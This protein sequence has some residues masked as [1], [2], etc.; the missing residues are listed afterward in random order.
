MST[1][2]LK[3]NQSGMFHRAILICLAVFLLAAFTSASAATTSTFYVDPEAFS[4][5]DGSQAAPWNSLH[6]A[7]SSISSSASGN[8]ILNIGTGTCNVNCE[9]DSVL[10]VNNPHGSIS[11]LQILGQGP[12]TTIIDGG[13]ASAWLNGLEIS[14]DNV[15]VEAIGIS[16]FTSG[17]GIYF[18]GVSSGTVKNCSFSSNLIGIEFDGCSN[19]SVID[20]CAITFN[21]QTGVL[22]NES[23]YCEIAGNSTSGIQNNGS[24]QAGYGVK[25]QGTS[26][27]GHLIHNN[28]FETNGDGAQEWQIY[29]QGSTIQDQIYENTIQGSSNVSNCKGIYIENASPAI[30]KNRIVNNYYGI[31][32]TISAAGLE[33][34]PTITNNL[35][36]GVYSTEMLSGISFACESVGYFNT[37]IFHNT[38]STGNGNAIEFY[39]QAGTAN[40]LYNILDNFYNGYGVK[41]A[42]GSGT[43]NVDYNIYNT[44]S[45]AFYG[46]T[47]G[48]NNSNEYPL[49][50]NQASYDYSLMLNS[51]C[52]DFIPSAAGDPVNEDIEGITRPQDAGWDAGAYEYVA[53]SPALYYVNPNV[54]TSGDGSEA[55]PWNSLYEAINWLTTSIT[56][57]VELHAA[58]G[59]YTVSSQGGYETD[60][61]HIISNATFDALTI[62][63]EDP[64][65]TI[66]SGV[67]ASSWTT[68]LMVHT[69]NVVI[70]N[71]TIENFSGCGIKF[72]AT[73]YGGARGCVL[74]NNAYGVE[75][76]SGQDFEIA[77]NEIYHNSLYGIF[78]HD[79]GMVDVYQNPAIYDNGSPVA[80][81]TGIYIGATNYGP[82]TIAENTI[83]FTGDSS[84]HQT[85][86]ISDSNES[87]NDIIS[88]NVITST[89]E[90]A[91][92]TG[93]VITDSN[94]ELN[95][96][97]IFDCAVGIS[98]IQSSTL[99]LSPL[100]LN[101]VIAKKT[102][103]TYG[104]TH[105]ITLSGNGG[106]S[107][108]PSIY[109]NTLYG[110]SGDGIFAT[111]LFSDI[112]NFN[113]N[114]IQDFVGYGINVYL[115]SSCGATA[116]YN[117]IANN[118]MGQYS[119][120]PTWGGNNI[121]DTQTFFNATAG[122]FRLA[123]GSSGVDAIPSGA[124]DSVAY[125]ARY[126][127]RPQNVNWD[128]GA[129]E[130][131]QTSPTNPILDD[132]NPA[133]GI[134]IV[135]TSVNLTWTN[136][137][138]NESGI[139]G[140]YW[141]VDSATNTDPTASTPHF[142]QIPPDTITLN[143]GANYLHIVALDVDG[144]LS[145]SVL[146]AGPWNYDDIP[147]S[148]PT[149]TESGEPIGV[150]TVN[151]S[152]SLSWDQGTDDCGIYG[153]FYYVDSN[154]SGSVTTS[155]TYSSSPPSSIMLNAETNYLHIRS[156]DNSHMLA[157]DTLTIGPWLVDTALPVNPVINTVSVITAT[158]ITNDYVEFNWTNSGSDDCGTVQ[159]KWCIDANPN[160]NPDSV[161]TAVVQSSL[162]TIFTLGDGTN[163]IH[164]VAQDDFNSAT[165]VLH[166]GPWYKDVAKPSNP[167]LYY[168]TIPLDT[169]TTITSTALTWTPGSDDCGLE[170][171]YILIDSIADSDPATL[172]V[173]E[174][175]PET[176]ALGPCTSGLGKRT[177][178][179]RSIRKYL[180]P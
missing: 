122:D 87:F 116:D 120:V 147:P 71:L 80:P 141:I 166:F 62:I 39:E 18:T 38:I 30:Y 3:A 117:A 61:S 99:S 104:L 15:T 170:G 125:D 152:T 145:D 89:V 83:F 158:C 176:L 171:Y 130:L 78:L 82:Y 26:G 153:Y 41:L 42:S 20:D 51:P 8:V 6:E 29:I 106:A 110:G 95:G 35:I 91:G 164:L 12:Y 132:S 48:A 109:H 53:P 94:A 64:S 179:L 134:C 52:I 146:H 19:V 128:M 143:S 2:T 93:I 76:S 31:R 131:D 70:K 40:V 163:W 88:Q 119:Q 129:Y 50:T 151:T 45:T 54:T 92:T 5:G 138:D 169:C 46:C 67:G 17:K 32:C 65:S 105:G 9:E 25:I 121:S 112:S 37:A 148:N 111:A 173:L 75:I 7:L 23:S 113:Y 22:L 44:V 157:S 86:G 73:S 84:Y 60:E 139:A 127:T 150:C 43:V 103:G 180:H 28:Y 79:S 133:A 33:A 126:V 74:R 100:V 72:E 13:G 167:I 114:I 11:S 177:A 174:P 66:I 159:Y 90:T 168:T 81:G 49:F 155:H 154:P 34:S 63:G 137:L 140:Y 55:N 172:G 96:N 160:T 21:E 16:G 102:E 69:T 165:E 77:Q 58:A 135:S 14:A 97:Q 4:S 175:L 101:N 162:P 156:K 136:G 98:V 10:T 124:G 57:T 149:L 36:Y 161:I 24:S 1:H 142:S 108:T 85:T 123:S 27:G 118:G 178:I 47:Q 144:N 115:C 107:F 56:G 68:G 59:A